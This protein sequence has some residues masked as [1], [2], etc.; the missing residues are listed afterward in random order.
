MDSDILGKEKIGKLLFKLSIPS[1]IAMFVN[2]LYNVVDTIFIGRGVGSDAIAAITV[3]FPIQILMMAF[4]LTIGVGTAS[5]ISRNLGAGRTDRAVKFASVSIVMSFITAVLMGVLGTIFINP[6]LKLFGATDSIIGYSRDYISIILLSSLFYVFSISGNNIV[7][8]IGK[9]KVS[10]VAMLVGVGLNIILDPIFIFVFKWGIKGAAYATVLSIVFSSLIVMWYI[11]FKNNIF[12]F[13][14][15][16]F[17]LKLEYVKEIVSV[18]LPTLIRNMSGSIVAIFVNNAL[19]MYGGVTAISTYGII[20]RVSMFSFMPMFG[21]VQG[22]QPVV[23]FNYGAKKFKRVNESVKLS[24]KTLVIYA[25]V[26][27]VLV[28]LFASNIFHIFTTDKEVIRLGVDAIRVVYVGFP[29]VGISIITA[30][31]YQSLGYVK[32][33][34]FLSLLRQVFIFIPLI[35]VLP[36]IFG[37]ALFG[38]LISFPLSDLLAAVISAFMIKGQ[39]KKFAS[40]T[41]SV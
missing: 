23:G 18:G 41:G 33:S 34:L 12:T 21:V 35:L 37:F 22:L 5:A 4:S 28:L 31:L 11:L 29:F 32:E 27:T 13:K 38:V 36:G 30:T 8:S 25:S 39:M 2:G 24:I 15:E 14:R 1:T 10:M 6:M 40:E 19:V 16:Y 26:L 7:R 17:N 9:A 20:H 3:A